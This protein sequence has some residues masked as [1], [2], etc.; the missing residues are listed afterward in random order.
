MD[1]LQLF[2]NVAYRH[3]MRFHAGT[4]TGF[5]GR[6][7]EGDALLE[8][9]RRWIEQEPPACLQLLPEGSAL[10]DETIELL[11]QES[12]LGADFMRQAGTDAHAKLAALGRAVEPDLLLLAPDA[13]GVFRP[14]AGSVCFPS[15]WSLAEKMGLPLEQIHGVVPGLNDQLGKAIQFYLARLPPGGVSLRENWGLSRSAELN[16]HPARHLPRL[17]ASIGPG[18]VWLRVE[19]QALTRLPTSGGILFGIRIW[20][21]SLLDLR[22][23]PEERRGLRLALATM[24]DELA[25]YKGLTEARSRL[26]ELLD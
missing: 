15:S 6:A 17:D 9:R 19:D 16:Q 26:L 12:M 22:E 4:V 14:V 25:A 24:P 5:F 1:L 8:Q 2:P 20:T 13:A 18:D 23:N 21:K 3:R 11:A 10:V 7:S